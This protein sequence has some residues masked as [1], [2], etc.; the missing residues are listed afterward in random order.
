MTTKIEERQAYEDEHGWGSS[1]DEQLPLDVLE[2][3]A[4]ASCLARA[5]VK[6]WIEDGTEMETSSLL[7]LCPDCLAEMDKQDRVIKVI[8]RKGA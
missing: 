4:C 5:T 6:A 2:I 8:E 7:W 3:N 1:S